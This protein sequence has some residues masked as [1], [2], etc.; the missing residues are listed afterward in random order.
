MTAGQVSQAGA[1]VSYAREPSAAASQF[2]LI[3]SFSVLAKAAQVTQAGLVVSYDAPSAGQATQAGLIISFS[4]IELGDYDIRGFTFDLDGHSFYGL[5]LKGSGTHVY[6]FTSGQWSVWDSGEL[7]IW[8]AQFH[9]H[10]QD[11]TYAA[12]VAGPFLVKVEPDSK[13]DDSFR[14]S[15][16]TATG[17]IEHDGDT[18]IPN[19]EVQLK[20]SAGVDAGTLYFYYSDDDGDTFLLADAV[21][22]TAGTR[23][24]LVVS[25]DL[26]SFTNPGRLF[27]VDDDGTVR[28]LQS[29]RALLGN[30]NG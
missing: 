10:W 22:L 25:Q 23:G 2:G 30:E 24:A 18:Y 8:N 14:T 12:E 16:F 11:D 29:L 6:D 19:P 4:P 21:T 7:G 28:R 1:I 27:R 20:G 17:R 13:L 26:G 9:V 5:H 15:T 3:V